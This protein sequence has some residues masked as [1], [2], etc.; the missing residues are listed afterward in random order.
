MSLDR[1]DARR[2]K[3]AAE[4]K[5]KKIAGMRKAGATKELKRMS[6]TWDKRRSTN[7]QGFYS[8]RN[9]RATNNMD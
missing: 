5:F 2:A 9:R 4:A 3:R 8:E 6:D 1:K 7:T